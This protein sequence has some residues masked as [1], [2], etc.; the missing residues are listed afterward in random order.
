MPRSRPPYPA[1][2]R[3]KMVELIRSGR[4]PEEL[5]REFEPSAQA[6]RNRV[7]Q[8]DLD[9]GRRKA[10]LGLFDSIECC[11]DPRRLHSAPGYQSP[12]H[13]PAAHVTTCPLNGG[14]STC[15]PAASSPFSRNRGVPAPVAADGAPGQEDPNTRPEGRR[16]RGAESATETP[17]L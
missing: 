9:E 3:M 1:G 4:T 15:P 8:A 16:A 12:N 14:N 17:L 11:Y 7:R 5:A 2:L 6:I 10:H 13:R